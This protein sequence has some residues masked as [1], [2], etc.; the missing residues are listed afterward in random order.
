MHTS[1]VTMKVSNI[2]FMVH[3]TSTYPVRYT[4]STVFGKPYNPG[5]LDIFIDSS[6]IPLNGAH[7]TI[8][9]ANTKDLY[10]SDTNNHVVR[11]IQKVDSSSHVYL[12]IGFAANNGLERIANR[13]AINSPTSIHMNSRGDLYVCDTGKWKCVITFFLTKNIHVYISLRHPSEQ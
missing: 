5:T 13:T 2:D 3:A 1:P 10:I 12:G 7:T 8:E 4:L 9:N 6:Q 11:V